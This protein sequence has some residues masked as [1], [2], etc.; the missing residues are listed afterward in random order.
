MSNKTRQQAIL[1]I[2]AQNELDTQE[3]LARLLSIDRS[4]LSGIESGKK[5]CSVDLF[6]QFAEFFHISLDELI[7]GAEHNRN[8]SKE[9]VKDSISALIEHLESFKASL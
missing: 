9:E 2:I 8:V 1:D 3:E 5:G 4:F 6:I 7:L